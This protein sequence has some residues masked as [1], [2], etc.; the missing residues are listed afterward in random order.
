MAVQSTVQDGNSKDFKAVTNNNPVI[1]PIDVAKKKLAKQLSEKKGSDLQQRKCTNP[2]LTNGTA[3]LA[4]RMDASTQLCVQS[5]QDIRMYSALKKSLREYGYATVV[6]VKIYCRRAVDD[7]FRQKKCLEWIHLSRRADL[8]I[9]GIK[10]HTYVCTKHFINSNGPTI[11]NPNPLPATVSKIPK[12]R[13]R[14]QRCNEEDSRTEDCKHR[15]LICSTHAATDELLAGEISNK[16]TNSNDRLQLNYN[17]TSEL[18]NNYNFT[19]PNNTELDVAPHLQI[20]STCDAESQTEEDTDVKKLK[21]VIECLEKKLESTAFDVD[22]CRNNVK[23][24]KYY[25]GLKPED[26]D[27]LWEFLGP[28][29]TESLRKWLTTESKTDRESQR[30]QNKVSLKNQLFLTLV[31]L[32]SGLLLADMSY[33]FNVSIGYLSKIFTTWIQFMYQE[34]KKLD[35]FP[36]AETIKKNYLPKVFRK[37]KNIR[38]IIDCFE[39]NMQKSKNFNQQG[40]TYSSYK[41]HNTV[42]FLVGIIP[43]KLEDVAFYRMVSKVVLVIRK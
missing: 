3:V 6:V 19:A 13:K 22:S 39:W 17:F 29:A 11:E 41:S 15:K 7:K 24:F 34:F 35:I 2:K 26:F 30:T 20:V 1:E 5:V 16:H 33:R 42:K 21:T 25:T 36:S 38:V 10:K 23:K 27:T 32:H 14:Q 31:R 9:D 12:D 18:E 28:P 37:F 43:T 4:K 40:N 8:T